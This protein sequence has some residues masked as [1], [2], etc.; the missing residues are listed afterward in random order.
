MHATIAVQVARLR[1]GIERQV[2]S[3]KSETVQ[4]L[5]DM[6][7]WEAMQHSMRVNK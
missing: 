7:Q 2:M 6:R 1:G 3:L 5:V 4:Q